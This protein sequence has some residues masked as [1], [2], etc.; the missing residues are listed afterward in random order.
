MN[1]GF[2]GGIGLFSA[3]TVISS[4]DGILGWALTVISSIEG[5]ASAANK[6]GLGSDISGIINPIVDAAP[7]AP[8]GTGYLRENMPLNPERM[9]SVFACLISREI[10][11]KSLLPCFVVLSRE[12]NSE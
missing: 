9:R 4:N 3:L 7:E 10:A 6:R 5:I 8:A 12:F 11:F 2:C 1:A